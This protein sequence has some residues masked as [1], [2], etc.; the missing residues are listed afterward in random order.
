MKYLITESSIGNLVHKVLSSD[1]KIMPDESTN[2]LI[3]SYLNSNPDVNLDELIGIKLGTLKKQVINRDTYYSVMGEDYTERTVL[4]YSPKDNEI[5][6]SL[7]LI[8]EILAIIPV[9]HL[10]LEDIIMKW[11]S[12]D[13]NLKNPIKFKSLRA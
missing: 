3:T 8:Y 9:N 10:D 2:K 7:Y 12:N 6:I 4:V 1:K 5:Y 11:A 13:L